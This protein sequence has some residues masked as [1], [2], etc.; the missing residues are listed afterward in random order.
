MTKADLEKVHLVMRA[1][2]G[3]PDFNSYIV[4]GIARLAMSGRRAGSIV[5]GARVS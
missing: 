3:E 4:R 2:Y 5:M 1:L